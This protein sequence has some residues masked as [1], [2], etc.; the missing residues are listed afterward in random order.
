MAEEEQAGAKAAAKTAKKQK[1]KAKNLQQAHQLPAP[2]L[3]LEPPTAL[4]A[5]VARDTTTDLKKRLADETLPGQDMPLA[6]Q[7]QLAATRGRAKILPKQAAL[8]NSVDSASIP[9]S[10]PSH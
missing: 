9:A 3:E 10:R 8:T 5:D 1:Q 2:D 7:Q 4:V 6:L